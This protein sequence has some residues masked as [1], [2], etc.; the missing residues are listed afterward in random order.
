MKLLDQTRL[1][2]EETWL[3]CREPQSVADAIYRLSVRGAPAIGV[4]AA[5]GLVL[6]IQGARDEELD[7]RFEATAELLGGTRP[8]AVNLRWAIERGR[9]VFR[10]TRDQ[11][12]QATVDAMTS[13]AQGVQARDVE[14]NRRLGDNGVALFKASDRV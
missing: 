2:A 12:A 7:A 3:E 8:T 14:T 11:G 10:A 1:P 6:G 9:E 4:S 5:Y 13:W